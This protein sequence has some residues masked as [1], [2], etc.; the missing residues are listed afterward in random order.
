[1]STLK[2][3]MLLGITDQHLV[4]LPWQTASR[5]SW[6]AIS[7]GSV[8]AY[9]LEKPVT[10]DAYRPGMHI[11]FKATLANTNACQVKINGLPFVPLKRGDALD[12]TGSEIKAGSLVQAVYDDT[13]AAFLV[14][15]ISGN[16]VT[17]GFGSGGFGNRAPTASFSYVKNGQ[18]V[19]FTDTSVDPDGSITARSWSFGDSQ[20]GSGSSVAHR[21]AS[22]T[23]YTVTLTV[24]DDQGAQ[25]SDTQV[26]TITNLNPVAQFDAS[27]NGLDASFTDQSTDSDGTIASR[28]WNFGDGGTSTA[29]NPT[30]TY[31]ASGT[32]NVT[33]TV[34]DNNGAT[35]TDT[36]TVSVSSSNV[37]PTANFTSAASGS[38]QIAFTD[39]SNDSDGS[40]V[41][42]L[43]NFGDGTTSTAQNPSHT[44]PASGSY[45]VRLTVTDNGGITGTKAVTVTTGA[46]PTADY[47]YSISQNVVTFTDASSA[48]GG[49]I[50][51]RT[52]NFSASGSPTSSAS[53]GP[54][55]VTYPDSA[56][57]YSVSLSV[58]NTLGL[59]DSETKTIQVYAPMTGSI[60]ASIT[61]NNTTSAQGTGT[62][63][64]SGG[65]TAASY[66]WRK[67]GVTFA[68][69]TTN[70][71]DLPNTSGVT[72]IL[73]CIV[74]S[75]G[76]TL[77]LTQANGNKHTTYSLNRTTSTGGG[78]GGGDGGGGCL[79]FGTPVT[80]SD[81]TVRMAEDLQTGDVLM[82]Y[83][84]PGM[85]DENHPLWRSWKTDNLAGALQVPVKIRRLEHRTNT[86][87]Q[88][89]NNGALQITPEHPVFVKRD[90]HWQ[91][92]N[93]GSVMPGD[94]MISTKYG[95]TTVVTNDEV[96]QVVQ[97][98]TMD[99]EEFDCYFAGNF[100]GN[101]VLVHNVMKL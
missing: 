36:D 101:Q 93:A 86:S 77:S 6:F 34:T 43:W 67:N 47:T 60:A 59:S 95:E 53:A 26:I 18:V 91:W 80:L 63:T 21:Y 74:T 27:A 92:I 16:G 78:G 81:G 90:G 82:G 48:G 94:M 85:L 45:T 20:V 7:T 54:V 37:G 1:M 88:D 55:A 96:Q 62:V 19:T 24:T 69:T 38:N 13:T 8:N 73:E 83:S 25:D 56:G 28:L 22:K 84:I 14:Y 99:V 42:W 9:E 72:A 32:Y 2:T 50:N 100:A 64:R 75:G 51:A 12:F 61:N 4:K 76:R 15:A 87:Y 70:T 79:L 97:V 10:V 71:V 5:L 17:Y 68:T 98:V 31:A 46:A 58:T 66:E 35:A 44:F 3:D 29:T 89:I 57:S 41:A 39:T 30:Y 23:S 11:N 65:A 33:L 49:T 40:V 52:W